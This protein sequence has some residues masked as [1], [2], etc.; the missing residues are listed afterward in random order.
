MKQ[1]QTLQNNFFFAADHIAV[2][3]QRFVSRFTSN[4]KILFHLKW[5]PLNNQIKPSLSADNGP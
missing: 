3:Y 4:N 5:L 2:P 1:T